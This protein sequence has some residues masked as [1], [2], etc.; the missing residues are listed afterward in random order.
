M[1]A[2]YTRITRALGQDTA[3]AAVLAWAL[4]GTLAFNLLMGRNWLAGEVELQVAQT[5]CEDL[6]LGPLI[7]RMPAGLQQR[8]GETGW[9]LSH[10]EKSRV[11]LA[12][13]LLQ[14]RAADGAGRELRRA[15]PAQP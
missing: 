8:V 11:F 1:P 3:V 14:Q 5:L 12:R 10:G 2:P 15:G 4:A 7:A 9:Q 13:A 6:G